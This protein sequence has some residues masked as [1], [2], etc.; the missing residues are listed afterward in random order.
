MARWLSLGVVVFG[1]VTDRPRAQASPTTLLRGEVVDADNGRAISARI[2]IRG[3]DGSCFFPESESP[4]GSAVPYRKRAIR[5]PSIE[6]R[7]G[8]TVRSERA[9]Q[10]QL[11]PSFL[12]GTSLADALTHGCI[13]PGRISARRGF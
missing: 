3:D 11:S 7:C 1:F 5:H 12:L 9:S 10:V 13:A 2:A 8:L 4:Q 6:R